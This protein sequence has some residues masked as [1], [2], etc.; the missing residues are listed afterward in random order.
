VLGVN[1]LCHVVRVFAEI[2]RLDVCELFQ[3]RGRQFMYRLRRTYT[4]A[5][6]RLASNSFH[7]QCG[8]ME[9]YVTNHQRRKRADKV[10]KYH[11]HLTNIDAI[12]AFKT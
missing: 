5:E 9:Q 3:Q 12:K 6:S 11:V 4:C 2:E 8:V 10:L 1:A 7:V